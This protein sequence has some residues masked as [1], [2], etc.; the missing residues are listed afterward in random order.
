MFWSESPRY[1]PVPPYSIGFHRPLI[2]TSFLT[3]LII[4]GIIMAR[5]VIPTDASLVEWGAI[6]KGR[7][8]NGRWGSH[9]FFPHK[10]S[11]AA[12]QMYNCK[13]GNIWRGV[14]KWKWHDS[15]SITKAFNLV[16]ATV[17]DETNINLDKID[18]DPKKKMNCVRLFFS[19]WKMTFSSHCCVSD[20][21]FEGFV[22]KH[23]SFVIKACSSLYGKH[24]GLT[25]DPGFE[26]WPW[27]FLY[28]ACMFS[29]CLHGF[30]LVTLV[31][32]HSP[33]TYNLD[34]LKTT[35]NTCN[36]I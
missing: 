32:S 24:C 29:L 2:S 13:W 14:P 20:A 34:S 7:T 15:A 4:M 26:W 8:V 27:S 12:G 11:G 23:F 9:V 30:S 3:Q 31:S 17:L 21:Y 25:A 10:L 28:G 18:R 22:V 36:M 19:W 16:P 35:V 1:Q 5:K 6:H 33:K